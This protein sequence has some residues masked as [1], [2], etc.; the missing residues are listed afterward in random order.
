M[1]CWF[2]FCFRLF[3]LEYM[4]ENKLIKIEEYEINWFLV[5][6][7]IK[8]STTPYLSSRLRNLLQDG[9]QRSLSICNN[10]TPITNPPG[11]G[12]NGKSPPFL[13]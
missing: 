7:D 1:E 5:V 6:S 10:A 8:N 9:Q 3:S 4:K 13:G 2:G 11:K 12:D